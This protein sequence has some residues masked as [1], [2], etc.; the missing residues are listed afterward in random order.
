MAKR[1]LLGRVGPA[2]IV[3]ACVIGPGSVTLMS[4]TGANYGYQLIWI[5]LL[6]GALM[7]GF[8]ALIPVLPESSSTKVRPLRGWACVFVLFGAV[9]LLGIAAVMYVKIKPEL[10]DIFGL[11]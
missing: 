2:F 11:G 1:G 9:V 6:S 8:L 3:G 7:A 10:M 4:T 5:S